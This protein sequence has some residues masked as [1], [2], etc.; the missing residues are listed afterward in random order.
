ML[1]LYALIH[2]LMAFRL[3]DAMCFL[4]DSPIK[5]TY[6]KRRGRRE[7]DLPIAKINKINKWTF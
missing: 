1:F 5:N 7:T 4:C 2:L 6:S 3:Y